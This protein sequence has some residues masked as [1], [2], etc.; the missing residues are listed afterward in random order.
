MSSP[1]QAQQAEFM[2]GGMPIARP[3][4]LV[5][6]GGHPGNNGSTSTA[7]IAAGAGT[8]AAVLKPSSGYLGTI[9]VTSTGSANLLFYDNPSAASGTII[10]AIPSTA[11]VGQTFSGLPAKNGITAGV[12]SGTPAV[13]VSFS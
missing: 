5:D 11:T 2:D 10:G 9:L 3:V 4:Y 1:T 13:T 8:S 6:N 12:L 7:T